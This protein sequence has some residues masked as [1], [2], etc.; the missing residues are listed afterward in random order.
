MAALMLGQNA[1]FVVGPAL[2]AVLLPVMGWG[3]I[4]VAFALI[5]LAAAGVGWMVRVR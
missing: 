2:F 3:S 1:G 4:G 5:G